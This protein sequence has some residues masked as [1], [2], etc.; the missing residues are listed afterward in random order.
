MYHESGYRIH[1]L[2]PLVVYQGEI[3]SHKEFK[4]KHLN[5]LRDYWFNGY[6]NE[7]PEYSGKI[8]LHKEEKYHLF[9]NGLKRSIDNYYNYLKVDFHKLNYHV[10]KTWVGYHKDDDTPSV[11][12]H[13]HNE[14]N[15][16]FVYYLKIGP[17]ADKLCF[18]ESKNRN[19]SVEG[20]FEVSHTHNLLKGYSDCNC[21]HY[22]LT[23]QEGTIAIFPSNLIHSIE[24]GEKREEERLVIAG[25]VRVTLNEKYYKHHQGCTHPSQW[26]QL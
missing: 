17:S 15:L 20:M 6:E 11:P 7:S 18:H 12:P 8:F 19:E 3:D 22:T 21:N 14:S 9:F 1:K 23:P 26:T 4:E 13:F 24:K 25:D 10:T 5:S 16:S 2:F